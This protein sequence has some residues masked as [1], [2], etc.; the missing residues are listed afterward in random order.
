[1]VVDIIHP[2]HISLLKQAKENCEYLIVG[3]Q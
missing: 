3:Y 1:M 2:G